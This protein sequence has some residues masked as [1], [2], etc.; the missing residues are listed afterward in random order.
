M[1]KLISIIIFANLCCN[2]FS[3]ESK[4]DG[5]ISNNATL[6]VNH[7]NEREYKDQFIAGAI[8]D[9]LGKAV[10]TGI[11]IDQSNGGSLEPTTQD[12]SQLIVLSTISGGLSAI[13]TVF[14]IKGISGSVKSGRENKLS[15]GVRGAGVGASFTF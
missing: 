5:K 10:L 2:A 15:I 14:I 3:Q 11:L 8:F 1:K 13:G 12:K 6:G 9:I 7:Q 4:P